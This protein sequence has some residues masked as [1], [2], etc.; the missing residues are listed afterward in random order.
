MY[1]DKE[2]FVKYSNNIFSFF[3]PYFTLEFALIK[4][5]NYKSKDIELLIALFEKRLIKLKFLR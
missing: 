1:Y 5:R 4:W 3:I 2:N